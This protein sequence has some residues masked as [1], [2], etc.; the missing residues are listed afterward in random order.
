MPTIKEYYQLIIAEKEKLSSLDGFTPNPETTESFINDLKTQSKVAIWRLSAWV[1]AVMAF[2]LEGKWKEMKTALQEI[3]DNTPPHTRSW[4]TN[5]ILAFQYGDST[6][7]DANGKV[8]YEVEDEDK[9]IVKLASIENV[10]G[11]W[12]ATQSLSTVNSINVYPAKTESLNALGLPV[13]EK[14]SSAEAASL[15]NYINE[16]KPL[17]IKVNVDRLSVGTIRILPVVYY[18]PK[19]VSN[20]G[21]LL[22]DPDRNPFWESLY[23]FLQNDVNANGI[24]NK[25]R[26]KAAMTNAEGVSDVD[27]TYVGWSATSNG[28]YV[29]FGRQLEINGVA[30]AYDTAGVELDWRT[31]D[32]L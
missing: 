2:L 18:D 6:V 8:T 19:I 11:V 30:I 1:F 13:Y 10:D 27:L 15:T 9:K 20:G 31:D 24:I 22:S 26:L 21:A 7:V 17:G 23:E 12:N 32:S 16:I 4:W 14:L 25:T 29:T 28:T 3:Q 5:A